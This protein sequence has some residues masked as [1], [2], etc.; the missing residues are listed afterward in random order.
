MRR[1]DAWEMRRPMARRRAN[2]ARRQSRAK[3]GAQGKQQD[4][5]RKGQK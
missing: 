4:W 1:H 5:A 2:W 3:M